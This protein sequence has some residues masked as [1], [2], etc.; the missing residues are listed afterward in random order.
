MLLRCYSLPLGVERIPA[1]VVDEAELATFRRKSQVGIVLAQQQPILGP[2]R[3]HAIGFGHAARDQVIDEHAEI[4]FVALRKPLLLLARPAR[5]IDAREQPLRT[6]LFVSGGA[7]YLARE[8]QV[9]QVL[10]FKRGA[11]VARVEVVILDRIAGLRDHRILKADDRMHEALLDLERHAR[12]DAIRVN[13]VR[14][15]PL[16]FDKNLV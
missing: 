7:V 5:C 4:G 6:G 16:G 14:R 11:E 12:R 8:V 15:Q 1:L 3:E 10:C 13:E 2:A 9:F